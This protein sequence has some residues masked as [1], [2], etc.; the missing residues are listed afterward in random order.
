[1]NQYEKH[2]NLVN[3]Y[4]MMNET[5]DNEKVMLMEEIG[6]RMLSKL[7]GNNYD[8]IT[9]I[10]TTDNLLV[11]KNCHYAIELL[12]LVGYND[13]AIPSGTLQYIDLHINRNLKPFLTNADIKINIRG[14]TKRLCDKFYNMEDYIRLASMITNNA[15]GIRIVRT[16]SYVIIED[17][18]KFYRGKT[19]NII[20]PWK[21]ERG[22]IVPIN[23]NSIINDSDKLIIISTQD[24]I[25]VNRINILKSNN[26][27]IPDIH[28][29]S[30]IPKSFEFKS[31]DKFPKSND[32]SEHEEMLNLSITSI[33]KEFPK[34]KDTMK[35][36]DVIIRQPFSIP[37]P[38]AL[39]NDIPNYIPE[40]IT[41]IKTRSPKLISK[42]PGSNTCHHEIISSNESSDDEIYENEEEEEEK[43]E[44]EEEEEEDDNNNNEGKVVTVSKMKSINKQI[45]TFIPIIPDFSIKAVIP[46][47]HVIPINI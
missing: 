27:Q 41:S 3:F 1:M 6:N 20:N 22:R 11:I 26:V 12:K 33:S 13:F 14:I 19:I 18:G 5:N 38:R 17:E 15:F 21:Q 44:E 16:R 35:V 2:R 25:H 32:I 46:V 23:Y 40:I 36:D 24:H 29:I 8:T 7:I 42:F 31:Y 39:R 45:T 9:R 28:N 37:K 10:R 43:E 34:S 47:K 30:D 4:E